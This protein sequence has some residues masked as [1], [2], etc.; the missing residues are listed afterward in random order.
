[1]KTNLYYDGCD[2]VGLALKY[3]TPLYVFS[4]SMIEGRCSE[5]RE[6]FLKRYEGSRAYYAGKAFLT[7]AMCQIVEKEGLGLDVVSGG[8]LHLALKAHFPPE[9]IIFHGNNKTRQEIEIAVDQGVGRIAVD[10]EGEI[11]II[12][13]AAGLK[14]KRA[15]ILLRVTPEVEALTHK[16]IRTGHRGS[17]FGIP[18]ER[19][20][21]VVKKSLSLQN[22]N[23]MGFHFHLGSQ[24]EDYRPYIESVDVITKVMSDLRDDFGFITKEL[25][26]GGGFGVEGF[27]KTTSK[28]ISYFVDPVMERIKARCSEFELPM[29]SV[30]IEPGRWIVSEAGIT[31]YTIGAIKEI[32]GSVTYV[33]VDGGMSDN[34]RPALYDAKYYAE[35][36]NKMGRPKD[37]VITVVGR[38]CESGD[39][40]IEDLAVPSDV[41]PGD[42]LAVFN[43]GAYNYS[44]ASNYNMLPKPAVVFVDKGKDILVVERE[45][46]DDLLAKQKFIFNV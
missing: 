27:E 21:Y 7:L 29:P 6:K 31:L 5:I 28:P 4:K 23:L 2:S 36:A 3:G 11:D 19:I 44:M 32:P 41:K 10:W 1:M 38:C 30:A 20:P 14:G 26:I 24:I 16:Y 9:R 18:L 42:I 35:V 33:S 13:K 39:I 46:Y 17:K 43:T 15:S 22:L 45:T 25:D 12:D 34:P 8:E 37:K 40:L